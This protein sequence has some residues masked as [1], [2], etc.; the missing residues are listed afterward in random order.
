MEEKKKELIELEWSFFQ[1]VQNEG[2]RADCQNNPET[3][4]IMR[5]SQFD[6]WNAPLIDSYL[7]DLRNKTAT[8]ENPVAEKYARMMEYTAPQQFLAL[9]SI[10][11][12]LLSDV[13]HTITEIVQIQLNWMDEYVRLYPRLSSRNRIVHKEHA[14][15]G[16]TSFETYLQSE[17]STY[18]LRT[19]TL[20]LDYVKKLRTEN[21]NLVLI[22]MTHTVQYYGYKNLDSAEAYASHCELK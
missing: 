8:G 10:L 21:S 13:Q 16:E 14:R 22:T 11:P 18:S 5:K 1:N 4:Y 6:S 12:P 2:G 17:L 15:I 19:L 9:R 3:F 7:T 20:Y